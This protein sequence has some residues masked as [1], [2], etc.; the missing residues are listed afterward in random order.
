MYIIYNTGIDLV[1][2]WRMHTAG[3][4][5]YGGI[6]LAPCVMWTKKIADFFINH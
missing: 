2:H 6:I 1:F 4:I 3:S 5:G